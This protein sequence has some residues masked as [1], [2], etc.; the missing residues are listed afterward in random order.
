M[1]ENVKRIIVTFDLEISM[2][3]SKPAIDDIKHRYF[4]LVQ[5]KTARR[6]L[7]PVTGITFY[8]DG[9]ILVSVGCHSAL[10]IV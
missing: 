3:G 10:K 9:E 7:S 8:L 6:L 1:A 4:A 2:V 5:V